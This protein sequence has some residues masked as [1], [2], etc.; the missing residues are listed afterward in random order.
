MKGS[1]SA[2]AELVEGYAAA[3]SYS[4]VAMFKYATGVFA[5][6]RALRRSFRFD[7]V[8]FFPDC[9]MPFQSC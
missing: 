8:L 1:F 7:M 3:R 6:R 2:D 4:G 5:V 9:S